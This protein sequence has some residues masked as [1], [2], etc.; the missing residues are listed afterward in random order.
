MTCIGRHGFSRAASASA[1]LIFVKMVVQILLLP[2]HFSIVS[3]PRIRVTPGFDR[4]VW[5]ART[6]RHLL[7]KTMTEPLNSTCSDSVPISV[8]QIVDFFGEALADVPFA[9]P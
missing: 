8:D 5:T 2:P 6:G 9:L 7:G 4:C 3:R 1:A